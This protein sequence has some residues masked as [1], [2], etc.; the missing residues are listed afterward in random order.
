MEGNFTPLLVFFFNDSETVKA[1]HAKSGIPDLPQS[2]DIRQ[3]SE[4]GISVFRI[5]GQ[6]LINGNCH[7]SRTSDDIEMKLGPVTKLDKKNMETSKKFDGKLPCHVGKSYIFV[8]SNLSSNK[9]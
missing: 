2:P 7:N 1:V 3:I 6:S 8:N 5:S 4:G 9:N